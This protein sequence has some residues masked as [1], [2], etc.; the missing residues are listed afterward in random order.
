MSPLACLPEAVPGGRLHCSKCHSLA[1][2]CMWGHF[3]DA[4]GVSD[5][6]YCWLLPLLLPLLLLQVAACRC[7]TR[8]TPRCAPCGSGWR[9]STWR[10]CPGACGRVCVERVGAVWGGVGWGRVGRHLE[11]GAAALLPPECAHLARKAAGA[12]SLARALL[13][14]VVG[15]LAACPAM[16]LLL[17]PCTGSA[18]RRPWRRASC[19]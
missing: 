6:E 14:C 7:T 18:T 1:R 5:L 3:V 11:R 17:V 12:G 10:C 8:Y 4:V 16:A 9:R 19:G 2:A 13:N 15:S